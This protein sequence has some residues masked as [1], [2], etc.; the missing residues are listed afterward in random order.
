M[1]PADR[2]RRNL[3]YSKTLTPHYVGKKL[4]TDATRGPL[5]KILLLYGGRIITWRKLWEVW[6]I[7][8]Q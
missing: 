6:S 4:G 7:N 1:R 3:L 8:F 2:A 5:V